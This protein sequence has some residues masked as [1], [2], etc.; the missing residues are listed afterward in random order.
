MLE[1]PT[2]KH[3]L[4][5][6]KRGDSAACCIL[7]APRFSKVVQDEIIPRIGYLDHRSE[8]HVHFYCAGYGGY[9]HK[10]L[11]PDMEEIGRGKYEDD[12]MIPWSFSQKLFG[13]FVDELERDTKWKYS[14]NVE[15]ILLDPQVDFSKALILDVEAMV[16]DGVIGSSTEL[17]EAIIRYCKRAAGNPSAY[18]FS[19]L[20]GVKEVGK[21]A[22]DLLLSA[23]PKPVRGIWQRGK[24]YAVKNL[25]A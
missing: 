6:R 5:H 16:R 7:I 25:V 18:D 17:F 10:D 12:T 19:D 1:A 4:A 21:G 9:W 3:V 13:Q 8:Q 22:I 24:H 14:G 2:L 11:I 15:L 20:Q 23:L